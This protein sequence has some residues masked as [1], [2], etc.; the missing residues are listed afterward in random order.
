MVRSNTTLSTETDTPKLVSKE[1]CEWLCNGKHAEESHQWTEHTRE[2]LQLIQAFLMVPM[3][4]SS[5]SG[6]FYILFVFSDANETSWVIF[7][8]IKLDKMKAR[9][10]IINT[11]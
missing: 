9:I 7:I 10:S 5:R 2:L 4:K 1:L 6:V 8:T 3:E 11:I